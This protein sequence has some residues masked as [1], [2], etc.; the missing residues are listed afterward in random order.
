MMCQGYYRHNQGFTPKWKDMEK[1][2]GEIIHTE[3]WPKEYD[4]K[5]KNVIVIGSG[6]TSATTIP[7]M[8]KFANH[9]TMLQRTPTFYRT[10]TSVSSDSTV[11]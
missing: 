8:T 1:F 11:R 9:V 6:A 2:K 4:Y 5:N 10:S 3:E 7:A